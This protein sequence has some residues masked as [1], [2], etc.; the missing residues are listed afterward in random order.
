M[1][2]TETARVETQRPAET[3]EVAHAEARLPAAEVAAPP[4]PLD[5]LEVALLATTGI[6]VERRD[7][8]V[9]GGLRLHTLACGAEEDVPLVLLHGRGGAGAGF[10]PILPQL[11]ARRRVITVDLPGWGLSEKPR[12]TGHAPEDALRVWVDG[13]L[14]FLDAEGVAQVDLLGHSMGGF[15]ALALALAHPER[16]RRLVL[17][18]CAGLGT[19]MQ[20]DV[21]L[22]FGL[23][24]EKLHRRFGK[25]L[26][27]LVQGHGGGVKP[28]ET[29]GPA[30]EFQHGL[31]TQAEVIPSGAAAFHAW[32]NLRGVH[33]TLA[34]RLKELAMPTLLLW[35]DRDTVT[36]YASALVAARYLRDRQLVT[37]SRCGHAPFAERPDDFA[38]AL[39]TWLDDIYVRP[40]I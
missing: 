39:L 24:P 30:F 2:P 16:V 36:P 31:L 34:E 27:R 20:R 13:A 35:G 18:D 38:H 4:S 25:R 6:A 32:I 37:L 21:R 7:V 33:L 14:A 28:G 22:Y 12:F 10:A 3:R 17:V 40:R 8:E 11:A 15:T 1:E 29:E 19:Q 9:A 5:A 26:T 23:G